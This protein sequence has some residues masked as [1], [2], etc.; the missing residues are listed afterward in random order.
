MAALL[1]GRAARPRLGGIGAE[2][3][4]PLGIAIVGG[5]LV[6]QLLTLYTTPVVYLAFDRLARRLA[7]RRTAARTSATCRRTSREPLDRPSSGRPVATTLLTV[8]VA[9]VGRPRL[10][11][12]RRCRRCPRSSSRPSRSRPTSPAPS[13]ETMASSVATPL[14]RQFGRIAGVTEMTSTQRPSGRPQVVLQFDLS[15]D[16]DAAARDV[17][18]AINAARGQLPANLPIEP[19]LPQGQ[20]GRRADPAAVAH[21]RPRT[22]EPRCTTSPPRS[23]SRSS[24]QVEGVGQVFVGGGALPAVRVEVNPTALNHYGLALEDVRAVLAS[25][26]ANRPKGAGRRR[27]GPPGRCRPRDQLLQGG[28][29][30]AARR[31]LPRRRPPSASPTSATSPTR[32]RTCGP[33][34]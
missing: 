16:I 11:A 33:A 13:P 14:E 25:A 17:Q 15:R 10:P 6:C 23:S 20:S 12:P 32:S 31:R 27:A 30:P 3:R 2:L 9:L 7:G 18:A 26:N 34:A 28:R 19:P 1:G 8:A 21:L 29:V 24:S 5:L 4:R 22:G